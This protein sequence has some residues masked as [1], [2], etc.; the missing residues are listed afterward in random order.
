[1]ANSQ[2]GELDI[3]VNGQTYRLALNLNALCEFQELMYPN[4]PDFDMQEVIGRIQKSNFILSRALLWAT[5]R[6]YHPE[7]TIR[8]VSPLVSGFG[9]Q[10]WMQLLPKL[11]EFMNPDAVDRGV[12]KAAPEA[13]PPGAQVD[14]IGARSM[15]KRAKLA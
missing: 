10:P 3:D 1:M 8:D 12:L 2:K 15:S 13:G 9:Y 7:M 11:M 5:L 14:G 4:D 6:T